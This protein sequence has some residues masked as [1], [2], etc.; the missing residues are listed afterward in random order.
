VAAAT[1][2]TAVAATAAPP[3]AA[4]RGLQ[5]QYEALRG[6]HI[7]YAEDSVPSQKIVQRMLERAGVRCTVVDN[8]EA[9]VHAAL[10]A[11]PPFDCILMD[12]NMPI[13]DGWGAT[14]DIQAVM[15]HRT[16]IIAVTANAMTGWACQILHGTGCHH[17]VTQETS[18][19][20]TPSIGA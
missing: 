16:P 11:S 19:P 9:A 17:D 15:D 18:A 1:T 12:C 8:G 4:S 6:R 5:P 14:R 10:H 13:L 3:T 7:L 2:A 20:A